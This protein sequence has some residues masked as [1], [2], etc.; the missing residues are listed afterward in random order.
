MAEE[1]ENRDEPILLIIIKWV[2]GLIWDYIKQI[3]KDAIRYAGLPFLAFVV[4]ICSGILLYCLITGTPIDTIQFI[5]DLLKSVL[6][7]FLESLQ[8]AYPG[9]QNYIA[10][11]T[12]LIELGRTVWERKRNKKD[13]PEENSGNST[14]QNASSPQ[15]STVTDH[16]YIGQELYVEKW[17]FDPEY[18]MINGKNRL[19]RL[20]VSITMVNER[21]RTE[22]VIIEACL[23]LSADVKYAKTLRPDKV[24]V[25]TMSTKEI[26]EVYSI[27]LSEEEF[28]KYSDECILQIIIN[29]K[30]ILT[31]NLTLSQ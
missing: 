4:I 2:I 16:T 10:A 21:N 28:N 5:P 26:K 24:Q 18:G 3:I 9:I 30:K 6:E 31:G 15:Q 8:E 14:P 22:W 27:D 17:E 12:S 29:R 23:F 11:A 20:N 13:E 19:R 7:D 25:I 1:N